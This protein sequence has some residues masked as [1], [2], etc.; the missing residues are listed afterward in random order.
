MKMKIHKLKDVKGEIIGNNGEPKIILADKYI[1]LIV[2]RPKNWTT[3]KEN[4]LTEEE[5]KSWS[6]NKNG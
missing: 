3:E 4:N 1:G 2:K 6:W 5:E